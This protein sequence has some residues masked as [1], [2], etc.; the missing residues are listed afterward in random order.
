MKTVRLEKVNPGKW[1]D[2]RKGFKV[3]SESELFNVE[4][5]AREALKIIRKRLQ[6]AYKPRLNRPEMVKG[7][8]GRYTLERTNTRRENALKMERGFRAYVTTP[9]NAKGAQPGTDKD[10]TRMPASGLT[11]NSGFVIRNPEEDRH[12][13]TAARLNILNTGF[14]RDKTIRRKNSNFLVFPVRWEGKW[15]IWYDRGPIKIKKGSGARFWFEKAKAHILVKSQLWARK[16]QIRIE[17]NF[18]AHW[19]HYKSNKANPLT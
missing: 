12:F 6:E 1:V 19:K 11:K 10:V 15:H 16:D 14:A 2:V 8:D 5:H 17:R 3:A 9:L 4:E 13:P 7:A 18:R